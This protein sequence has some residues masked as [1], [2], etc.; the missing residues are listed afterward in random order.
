MVL[1]RF[2]KLILHFQFNLVCDRD[3]FPTIGLAALNTGGPIGVYLFGIINDRLGRRIAYFTCLATLLVGSFI[4]AISPSFAVWAFS[5]AIV[6]LTI[7]AV[8]QIP[9][10]IGKSLTI[11]YDYQFINCCNYFLTIALELVGPGYRSFVTVM[12]CTFY[13]FGIMMLAGVSYLIRDWVELSLYTSVPFL[14]YFLYILIM[15]ESPRWLLARGKLEEALK[16]LEVMARVNKK[17]LPMAFRDRLEARVRTNK[18]QKTK[19]IGAFDLC[20]LVI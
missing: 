7:P 17:Q 16:V 3:I 12:T 19:S 14:L 9:F 15:P 4:T 8:Y 5:R 2:G 11:Q 6:G 10:I 13:T 1:Q 20:K 18:K